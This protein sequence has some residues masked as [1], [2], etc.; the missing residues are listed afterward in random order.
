MDHRPTTLVQRSYRRLSVQASST[1]T[2]S[3]SSLVADEQGYVMAGSVSGVYSQRSASTEDS[4]DLRVSTS[5]DASAP[6][7]EYKP[8]TRPSIGQQPPKLGQ[9]PVA[10]AKAMRRPSVMAVV[11]ESPYQLPQ[12]AK[13]SEPAL[14][15][16]QE[17]SPGSENGEDY[18]EVT[19]LPPH[20]SAVAAAGPLS[21]VTVEQPTVPSRAFQP[22]AGSSAAHNVGNVEYV[23][24]AT[25]LAV[26]QDPTLLASEDDSISF[27]DFVKRSRSGTLPSARMRP[28]TEAPP[29]R[30]SRSR[31]R[32][33]SV[34]RPPRFTRQS[35]TEESMSELDQLTQNTTPDYQVALDEISTTDQTIA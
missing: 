28:P 24:K 21:T 8:L 19:Q 3:T 34:T 30:P 18:E 7:S 13:R 1:N 10:I 17:P 2:S 12:D 25:I 35:T 16:A 4:V 20:P 14:H 33:V 32:L 11:E 29:S 9:D 22:S 26:Q 23:N 5:T 15:C 31:R 6:A 27:D